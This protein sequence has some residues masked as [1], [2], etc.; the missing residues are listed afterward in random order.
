MKKE[1][2]IERLIEQ[3]FAVVDNYLL[4]ASPINPHDSKSGKSR[5]ISSTYGNVRTALRYEGLPVTVGVNAFT[6]LPQEPA[7]K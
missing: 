5:T 2:S 3:G 6:A 4:T 1:D 7:K